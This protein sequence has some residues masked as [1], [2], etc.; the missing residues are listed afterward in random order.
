MSNSS[1]PV[2]TYTVTYSITN[3]SGLTA[4]ATRTVRII[5]PTEV[6]APRQT[7]N[8]SG[9]GKVGAVMNHNGVVCEHA[10]FMD[11]RATSVDN[12]SAYTVAVRNAATGVTVYTS[13]FTAVGG[14]QFWVDE[15]TYNIVVTM[16]EG[17]GNCKYGISVVTPEVMYVTFHEEEVALD[18]PIDMFL[19]DLGMSMDEL[20]DMDYTKDEMYACMLENGYSFAAMIEFGFTLEELIAYG[21]IT[22][23]EAALL[24]PAPTTHTVVR[25]DTLWGISRHYYGTGT[26][27]QDIR[28]AN[29]DVIGRDPYSLIPG[30][31]LVLPE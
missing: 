31:K 24:S 15:G 21:D 22:A 18:F 1:L 5:S 25:G 6:R 29:R 11:F 26:R 10:G 20:F 16:T 9:Q 7:Y 17:N 2:G 8:F 3:S 4:T 28:D 27:W 19:I 14:T 30:M 13:K 23:E 12:K